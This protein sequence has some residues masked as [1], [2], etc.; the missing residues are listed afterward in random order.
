[1]Y[2]LSEQEHEEILDNVITGIIIYH[3]TL[4]NN[5][6]HIN[7]MIILQNLKGFKIK[8]EY[9]TN[10]NHYWALCVQQYKNSPL[11]TLPLKN[12]NKCIKHNNRNIF[13][14]TKMNE[15][16]DTSCYY[17]SVSGDPVYNIYGNA[18]SISD[19]QLEICAHK[20]YDSNVRSY[21]KKK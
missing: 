20:K 13:Q 16:D 2:N 21:L 8:E 7:K 3:Q 6:Q 9:Y 10:E 19:V 17:W 11:Y 12:L 18:K 4:Q 1:M 14:T 15:S 5:N